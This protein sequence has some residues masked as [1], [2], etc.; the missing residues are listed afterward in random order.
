M[1]SIWPPAVILQVNSCGVRECSDV[2][3]ALDAMQSS[4]WRTATN[5]AEEQHKQRAVQQGE[6]GRIEKRCS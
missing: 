5:T 4:G 1:F 6:R 2:P 3:R